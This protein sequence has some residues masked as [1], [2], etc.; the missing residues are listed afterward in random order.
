MDNVTLGGVAL[1]ISIVAFLL[2]N[3]LSVQAMLARRRDDKESGDTK[4]TADREAY[5][6]ASPASP[7]RSSYVSSSSSHTHAQD[8][9]RAS[10]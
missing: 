9:K 2:V 10:R 6:G 4:W 7:G 8:R 3:V 5:A 1:G